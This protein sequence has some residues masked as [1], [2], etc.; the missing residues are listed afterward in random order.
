MRLRALHLVVLALAL[1]GSACAGNQAYLD[2]RPGLTELDFEGLYEISLD[3]FDG[4]AREAEANAVFDRTRGPA[5]ADAG[6]RMAALGEAV[7]AAASPDPRGFAIAS[8]TGDGSVEL[9]DERG[10]A[11]RGAVDWLAITPDGRH[12]ALVSGTKLA[13]AIDGA[14][15][16]VELGSLLGASLGGTRLMMLVRDEELTVFALP[17]LGGAV[18]ANEPGYLLS[19]RSRPGAREPWEIGVAR[20]IIKM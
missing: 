16:G 3:E 14:S 12:A 11:Q 4:F 10:A 15:T 17:E 20:V 6:A 7:A 1:F 2:W 5:Q 19:F 13:V 18:S 8:L 9:T